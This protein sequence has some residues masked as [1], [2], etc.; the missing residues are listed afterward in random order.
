MAWLSP[1]AGASWSAS[2]EVEMRVPHGCSTLSTLPLLESR[3]SRV[4]KLRLSSRD[5]AQI[6][7][8]FRSLDG[9]TAELLRLRPTA[10]GF[11]L[12]CC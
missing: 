3:Y 10:T 1:V 11:D 4:R 6:T 7:V 2:I 9:Q 12:R 8:C 5:I